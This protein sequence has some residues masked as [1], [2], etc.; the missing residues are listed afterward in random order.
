MMRVLIDH[1]WQS[2]LFCAVIWSITLAE[3]LEEAA[4]MMA[5]THH[6]AI[7]AYANAV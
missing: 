6:T 3:T 2:T 5:V 1:L 7:A 4:P